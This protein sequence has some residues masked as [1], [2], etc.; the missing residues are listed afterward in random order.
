MISLAPRARAAST[1]RP[2]KSTISTPAVLMVTLFLLTPVVFNVIL[3]FTKWQKFTG[4]D[5][6]AGF[7]NYARLFRLPYFSEALANTAVW[8]VGAVVFPVAFAHALF[9]FRRGEP[10]T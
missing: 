4:L 8:V 5:Q 9:L 3:S 6:F 10:A 7:N 2:L 1:M